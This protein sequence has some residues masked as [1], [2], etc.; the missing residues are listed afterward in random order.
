MDYKKHQFII[1]TEMLK[2]KKI[3]R[4]VGTESIY[5]MNEIQNLKWD[6]LLGN[7]KFFWTLVKKKLII[8]SMRCFLHLCLTTLQNL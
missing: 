7:D 5:L 8:S 2:M 6:H 4:M 3:S 1:I